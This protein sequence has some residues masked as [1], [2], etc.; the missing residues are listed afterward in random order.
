MRT[1]LLMIRFA[2][3]N[4]ILDPWVYI[5]LRREIVWNVANTVKR[6]FSR[7]SKE[8]EINKFRRRRSSAVLT[9]D[10]HYTCCVF[11]WHCLCDYSQMQRRTSGSF[12]NDYGRNSIYSSTPNSSTGKLVLNVMSNVMVPNSSNDNSIQHDRRSQVISELRR[13]ASLDADVM[14]Q[15]PSKITRVQSYCN[16]SSLRDVTQTQICQTL[17]ESKEDANCP[18]IDCV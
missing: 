2:S 14:S 13:K 7:K 9:N 5:L 3:F 12:H 17:V 8:S 15:Q 11:C 16:D 4:Q 6:L 1:D 18:D 10:V